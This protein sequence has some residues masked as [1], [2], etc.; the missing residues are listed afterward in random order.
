MVSQQAPMTSFARV[1]TVAW[2]Q[3]SPR[4]SGGYLEIEPLGVDAFEAVLFCRL[5]DL[6][7]RPSQRLGEEDT[8]VARAFWSRA[9]RSRSGSLC[10]R[11]R[12][13]AG[14]KRNRG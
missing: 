1:F 9:R 6:A 13:G 4:W 7:E 3:S 10:P 2:S 8:G 11:R 14:R 5:H 12:G